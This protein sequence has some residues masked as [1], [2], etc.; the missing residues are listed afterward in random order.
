[1][2][3]LID[4]TI[5]RENKFHSA[6]FN[7]VGHIFK[8]NLKYNSED[9]NYELIQILDEIEH[10]FSSILEEILREYNDEDK[11]RIFLDH[12]YLET[13]IHIPFRSKKY[14]TVDTIL[15][16]IV[17][18]SQ[19]KRE[20]LFQGT[21][22]FDVICVRLNKVGGKYI[23]IE[24]WLKN[25]TK[26]V[27]VNGDGYC[28][29]KSVIL[30]MAHANKIDKKEWNSLRK[31]S[32]GKLTVKAKQLYENVG[33]SVDKDGVSIDSIDKIQ[34]YIGSE[35][36]LIAV[37]SPDIIIYS[38]PVAHKQ[39]F[40]IINESKTHCNSLLSIK[41]FLKKK[42]Y[43][44][45][46]L[47]GFNKKTNHQCKHRCKFCFENFKCENSGDFIK[48]KLCN[49][50]FI[51]QKC[52]ENH[53]R[54]KICN[55][56][57]KC[58]ICDNIRTKNHVC[59]KKKCGICKEIVDIQSHQCYITPN[60]PKMIFEQDRLRKIFVFY[61]FEC[62]TQITAEGTKHIVNQACC[63]VCCDSCWSP[64]NKCKSITCQVCTGEIQSFFGLDAIEKFYH[65]IFKELNIKIQKLNGINFKYTYRMI[66][67]NSR[68][69]DL[70]FIIKLLLE[71]R[72]IPKQIKKGTKLLMIDIF[73]SK[74]I[75]SFSF[76]PLALKNLP[77]CFGLD[78]QVVHK[79]FFP[80]RFNTISNWN[81]VGKY[82]DIEYYDIDKLTDTD[83]ME[84]YD[85]Y[86][87]V[88]N[89]IF[90]FQVEMKKYC[91][92]DC[93]VLLNTFMTFRSE[94]IGCFKIDCATRAITISQSVM[95][96]FKTFYLKKKTIAIIPTN[97]YSN[98][99][100][101]SF[102]ANIFLDYMEKTRN[103]EIKREI[104][105][106]RYICDGYCSETNEVF[107]FFGC[108]THGC[109]KCFRSSKRF[110]KINPLSK[111][112]MN[113]LYEETL[114]KIDCY[115]K[116]NYKVR[117]IWECEFNNLIKSDTMLGKFAKSQ[118]SKLH[119]KK[120]IPNLNPRDAF[121]GGR[122]EPATIYHKV[123]KGEKIHN[124]DFNSLYP[125][126][127]VKFPYPIGHPKIFDEFTDVDVS[128][129][130][131]LIF[132]TV[133]PPNDL[134]FP[135]LP[136][137]IN[138]RLVFTSCYSCADDLVHNCDHEEEERYLTGTWTSVELK[139]AISR[140]YKII[141]IY[142]VWHFEKM[143]EMINGQNDLFADFINNCISKKIESSGYPSGVDDEESK[144]KYI[145]DV[146]DQGN[147]KLNKDEIC[148]NKGRRLLFKLV[149]NSFWG[150]FGQNISLMK[151]SEFI[152]KTNKFFSLFADDDIEVYDCNIFNDDISELTYNQKSYFREEHSNSNCVIAS[153]VTAYARIELYKILEKLDKRVL[154][155]DTD[156]VIFKA[157][158]NE[159]KP[160]CGQF[161]GQLTN[162]IP[163]GFINEFVCLGPKNYCYSVV[164]EKSDQV[165]YVLKIKGLRLN[166]DTLK[167]VN[168]ESMKKLLD[169][170]TTESL[171]K[172][173]KV[174]QTN[175][176]TLWNHDIIT[177]NNEKE[178]KMVFT[179]RKLLPDYSTRPF[180]YVNSQQNGIASH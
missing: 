54:N 150:K 67:H 146:F 114:E 20:F 30:S 57:K 119:E 77:Y 164:N 76:I 110:L 56:R 92:N 78:T 167:I 4:A 23:D 31:D 100:T 128:H 40:I 25:S 134:Y 55:Q 98:R 86:K 19:S 144:D 139:L 172:T 102:I 87:S 106:N 153:F 152:S 174:P 9:F 138:D 103:L 75:D 45:F 169:T 80:Y 32:C 123:L 3:N 68:S 97:G 2:S 177:R 42:Y 162:E 7:T 94:W 161:L 141:K 93:Y 61:D 5:T 69:Y 58:D 59:Y 66:A 109:I 121:H 122:V 118:Y 71:N 159:Y 85:W 171:D 140:N 147:I 130:D 135:I 46:C 83:K 18:V 53:K 52:F 148:Y 133:L 124:F 81:Y 60:D 131:G 179:K 15:N 145:K 154:Y 22:I 111:K 127:N 178:Y 156:S 90:D 12:E 35:Y 8:V 137:K 38:G 89:N 143:T 163:N 10:L 126:C 27:R 11:V 84:F 65:Y 62:F 175:F 1:M 82:P 64:Q 170:Y 73:K 51:S 26:V 113:V 41:A 157:K 33:L 125:S 96:I 17:R 48:C 173:L 47:V 99:R 24:T 28:L 142:E 107:E 91:L 108:F 129:Y 136:L 70:H 168:F 160:S 16:Q 95:E 29:A 155:Y 151:K 21:L 132:C 36:Q 88:A 74:F 63:I 72:S 34:K 44:K 105:I 37:T 176:A 115:R 39:I 165:E 6:K 101:Q 112:S 13:P 149:V 120:H 43:C 49:R 158:E 14:I 180:G 116:N 104:K 79:G 166:T 117:S 50:N